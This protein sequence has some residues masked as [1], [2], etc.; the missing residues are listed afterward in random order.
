MYEL[1]L[2]E[3]ILLRATMWNRG[4]RNGNIDCYWYRFYAVCFRMPRL[5]DVFLLAPRKNIILH[6]YKLL[7]YIYTKLLIN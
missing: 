7:Y 5:T 4:I 1:L 2:Q 6:Y 3:I